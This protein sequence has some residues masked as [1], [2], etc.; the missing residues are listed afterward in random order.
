MKQKEIVPAVL[1]IVKKGDKFL[2]TKRHSK[3]RFEAGKWGFK[4]R[5]IMSVLPKY[6]ANAKTALKQLK[7]DPRF[8]NIE[9]GKFGGQWKAMMEAI[10][11]SVDNR[12]L[13]AFEEAVAAGKKS[14]EK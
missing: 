6:G 1:A 5:M 14:E 4:V 12:E 3:S 10:E 8:N 11:S 13:I 9:K 2:L 7:A